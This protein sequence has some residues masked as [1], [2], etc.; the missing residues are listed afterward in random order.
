MEAADLAL[1]EL[2]RLGDDAEA[3][4]VVGPGDLA[5]GETGLDL[6]DVLKDDAISDTQKARLTVLA[7]TAVELGHSAM[8][9]DDQIRTLVAQVDQTRD[10]IDA[11]WAE[12][13]TIRAAS[14]T[15]A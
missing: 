11:V 8:K 4:P 7:S 12:I 3:A 9:L 14:T 15:A 6:A 13:R 10:Q 5:A 2:D 1:P